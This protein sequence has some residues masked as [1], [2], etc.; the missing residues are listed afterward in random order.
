M[1][2]DF[3]DDDLSAEEIAQAVRLALGELLNIATQA[4]DM[5]RT[6][7]AADDIYNICD[8]VAE[9]YQIE[10]S[11]CIVEEND[12]GSFT[13]RFELLEPGETT[14][15][16]APAGAT[17]L[18][19]IPGSIRTVG[20]LKFRVIDKVDVNDLGDDDAAQ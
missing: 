3:D 19:K 16:N 1:S 9:Y 18:E 20:K 14:I 10:R 15:S 6:D 7:E 12:D 13:T 17:R 4:G 8:L 2:D 11:Q 5:Q